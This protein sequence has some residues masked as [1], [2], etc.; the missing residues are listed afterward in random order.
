ME[1]T[2]PGRGACTGPCSTPHL[3]LALPKP[4]CSGKPY[5]ASLLVQA[6]G[7]TGPGFLALA[8]CRQRVAQCH[9]GRMARQ[10]RL[11]F[12][13]V[14]AFSES[15]SLEQGSQPSWTW[16][17]RTLSSW[18]VPSTGRV[19]SPRGMPLLRARAIPD[20]LLA[21]GTDAMG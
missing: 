8:L 13:L 5:A 1:A 21:R 19:V 4:Q 9:G 20:I 15:R 12:R 11:Q 14:V 6:E 10:D 7:L 3:G 18:S 2:I 17:R 16:A